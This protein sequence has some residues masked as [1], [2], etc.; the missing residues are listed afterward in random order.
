MDTVGFEFVEQ[1]DGNGPVGKR[2]E[3]C[4]HPIDG[5]SSQNR[6]LV[7]FADAGAF[8]PKVEAGDLPR[9]ILVAQRPALI[10]AQSRQ[11]PVFPDTLFY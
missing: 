3:E 10:F 11:L 5:I 9:Q 7:A 4:H 2:P 8:E 1:R 6:H